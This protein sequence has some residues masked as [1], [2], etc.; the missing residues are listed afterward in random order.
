MRPRT[1]PVSGAQVWIGSGLV[2]LA[3]L[4]G[5]RALAGLV[6]PGPWA[7]VSTVLV[8]MLAAFTA[9]LRHAGRSRTAPS[10][11]G[12]AL[13]L[14]ALGALYTG[15]ATTPTLP[16]P[17]P[18]S[19]ERF[20]R[21]VRSG[22]EGVV[23]G[24]IPV[25]PSRGIELLVVTGAVAVFLLADLLA[26]GL[27][28]AGLAGV[29]V[30]G[31]WVPTITFE[32]APPV[33][34]MLLGGVSF[35]LLLT[36]TRPPGR[37]GESGLGRDGWPALAAAA[38]V[39]VGALVAGPLVGAAPFYGAVDLPSAWTGAGVDGPLRLSTELDMRASLAERSDR[40]VL[41]Y[42]TDAESVGP[43]RLYTVVDFDGQEW[44]RG[45]PG[46]DL[47]RSDGVLWPTPTID[48]DAVESDR[49]SV[50]IGN[51]D[52]E[53]LPITTE[54]RALDVDGSWFYDA[55]RDEV[56][57]RSGSTRDSRYVV[58]IFPRDLSPEALRADAPG[59]TYAPDA[60][61]LTVPD[62]PFAADIAAL[63]QEVTAASGTPYDRAVALQS[64]FRNIGDFT[65]DTEV[66]A[67]RT[68]DAVWDFLTDRTGYCV[69][70][71]TAMTVMARTLGIPARLAIGF[72]PGR[73]NP[74]VRGEYVVTGRQAHAWPELYFAGAGWV[75]FEPTPAVQTGAPPLYADPFAGAATTP[76]EEAA[77]AAAAQASTAPTT[78]SA[79]TV[80]P[81]SS[82]RVGIGTASLP[83]ALVIAVVFVLVALLTLGGW[84]WWRRHSHRPEA[85]PE[86][87][88]EWWSHLRARLATHGVTWSDAATPR[89]AADLVR[90]RLGQD[91]PEAAAALTSLATVL[92]DSRYAPGPT[93][94]RADDLQEWATAVERPFV[95]AAERHAAE[96]AARLGLEP[97]GRGSRGR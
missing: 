34:V 3:T 81:G 70:Y 93:P 92:E 56:V 1:A 76:E 38:A 83:V 90:A 82:G 22:V 63:A 36:L 96:E 59:A 5:V 39:T 21:L 85:V 77:S 43:L 80:Q 53:R 79:A 4:V 89:Q 26:L 45:E 30:L 57:S 61:V 13:A 50:R 17:T 66:P 71:A 37:T 32:L 75:R 6:S 40:P 91:R 46:R 73:A 11:W 14:V 10:A 29:A 7:T 64:F 48:P 68:E 16:L 42:T 54:P 8:L 23:D 97:A 69:Q 27:G 49:L 67:P 28:R 24:R 33:P 51:L 20:A 62:T 95:E 55:E 31:L 74:A 44:L 86:G 94:W 78:T 25:E 2:A 84:L 9:W 72:L 65:Y 87:P 18:D 88:E 52:Q 15:T 60:A 41:T 58:T 47:A 35:L 12:L 19:F